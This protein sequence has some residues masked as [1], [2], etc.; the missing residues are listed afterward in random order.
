MQW[1]AD[2]LREGKAVT[3]RPRGNSM[4]PLIKNGQEVTVSPI[5]DDTKIEV[6]SILL[7][8]VRGRV[9]LHKVLA[10]GDSGFLIGSHRGAINGWTR[11]IYGIVT[12]K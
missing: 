6:D 7:C 9:L 5:A 8:R 10:L 12:A 3:F 2:K 11:T 4:D 1:I